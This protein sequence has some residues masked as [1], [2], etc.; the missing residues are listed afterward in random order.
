MEDR[1]LYQRLAES[2]RRDILDGKLHPGDQLPSIRQMT[3]EWDCTPGTVQRAYQALTLQGLASTLAG[4]GTFVSHEV[5]QRRMQAEAPLRQAS[6]VHRAETFLLE[7]LASGYNLEEIQRSLNLAMDR[8][9]SLQQTSA[10]PAPPTDTI[11]FSGSH[12]MAVA[13]LANNLP[14]ILPGIRLEAH[15]SGSLGGLMALAEGTADLAGCHLWDAETHTYNDA[16][17]RKLFP[18]KDLLAI[19]LA[20]RNLGWILQLGNPYHV[21]TVEDLVQPGLRFVNRQSGSGTR[22]WLDAALQS[23][24][25]PAEQVSGY[26]HAKAT[27]S[28]FARAIAED[29]ADVGLGLESAAADF[30]LEF[31]LLIQE[32]YDLVAFAQVGESLPI[33]TL[34]NWLHTP[35]ARALVASL[36]G[37][38]ATHTG[39]M[40][41]LKL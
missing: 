36:P 33:S 32:Q 27:H 19:H 5:N 20:D 13:W 14:Q 2:I 30:G 7:S 26:N 3:A 28:E 25:I 4:K 8:W 9:R 35:D 41:E 15:Y 39:E 6:M 11:R 22:V 12:D 24:G 17:L 18:G 21:Q 38:D 1:F 29:Q 16:F 34:I 37:Y 23:A 10:A 31:I 40:R